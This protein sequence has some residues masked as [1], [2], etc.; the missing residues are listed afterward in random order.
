M[1][2]L[3]LTLTLLIAAIALGLS[4]CDKTKELEGK[5]KMV[6]DLNQAGLQVTYDFKPDGKLVQDMQL[7]DESTKM[8]VIAQTVSTYS[9]D[10]DVLTIKTEVKDVNIKEFVMEG[11]D[12]ETTKS[13]IEQQKQ[14]MGNVT[15]K[16]TDIEF[17]GNMMTGKVQGGPIKLQR[18]N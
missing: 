14:S 16:I 9:L 15:L 17:I 1:R 18:I 13:I 2:H 7:T 5:W 6:S 12:E 10:G 11:M 3:K 8:K 4:S